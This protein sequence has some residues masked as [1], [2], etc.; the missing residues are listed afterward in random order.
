[1]DTVTCPYCDED[2]ELNHDDGKHYDEDR[3]EETQCSSCDKYFMV[4]AFCLW[5]FEANKAD[6]LN[7]GDHDWQ[8][9]RGWPVGHFENRRRCSVCGEEKTIKT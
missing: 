9:I 2:V 1:M 8:K 5:T 4:S 6:C 3:S 7:D